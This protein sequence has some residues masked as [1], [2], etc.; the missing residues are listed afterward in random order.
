MVIHLVRNQIELTITPIFGTVEVLKSIV[1][2]DA[3]GYGGR[4]DPGLLRSQVSEGG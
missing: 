3:S 2:W 4:P 1:G